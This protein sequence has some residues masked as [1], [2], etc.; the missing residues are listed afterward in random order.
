MKSLKS[1]KFEELGQL[2]DKDS[3]QMQEELVSQREMIQKK[4]K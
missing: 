4:K 1:W 3:P 2:L